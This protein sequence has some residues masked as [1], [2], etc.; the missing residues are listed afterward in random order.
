MTDCLPLDA[1]LHQEHLTTLAVVNDLETRISIGGGRPIDPADAQDRFRLQDLIAM[2]E[3]DIFRHYR[4]EEEV[5]FP[6]L[7]AA[8][9]HPMTDM[10][11]H[12]HDG[13]R[14]MADDLRALAVAALDRGF[15]AAGWRAFRDLAADFAASVT[16]HI[17][18]EEM[19]VV[20]QVGMVLG[21]EANRELGKVYAGFA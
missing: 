14:A 7:A 11:I 2:V 20:R 8:G 15:D 3:R 18:K 10:L 16:F 9:L 17:Q 6:R 5:L 13:V 4:F 19:G 21:A 12:E 1:M